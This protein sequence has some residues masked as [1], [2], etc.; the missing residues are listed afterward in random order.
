MR[1]ETAGLLGIKGYKG[2][3][4]CQETCSP[5]PA[6]GKWRKR[7]K[8]EGGIPIFTGQRKFDI[9]TMTDDYKGILAENGRRLPA[10]RS[11]AWT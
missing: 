10:R 11:A 6:Y 1:Y 9:F 5:L 8:A 7:K 3:A 2:K 4:G